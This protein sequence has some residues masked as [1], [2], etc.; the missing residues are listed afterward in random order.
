MN[1]NVYRGKNLFPGAKLDIDLGEI[2][3]EAGKTVHT[4]LTLLK[5]AS[6]L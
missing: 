5:T 3:A 1:G 6:M 2:K 4:A